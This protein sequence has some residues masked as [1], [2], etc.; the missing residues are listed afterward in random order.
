LN[1]N[2]LSPPGGGKRARNVARIAARGVHDL[3]ISTGLIYG[4]SAPQLRQIFH[5]DLWRNFG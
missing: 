5:N 4:G 2:A 3:S 1:V